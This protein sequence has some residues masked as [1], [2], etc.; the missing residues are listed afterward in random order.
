MRYTAVNLQTGAIDL[1]SGAVGV[2]CDGDGMIST[3]WPSPEYSL[4]KGRPVVFRVG[5][6]YVSTASVDARTGKVIMRSY[7]ATD[8]ERIELST[9]SQ[10]PD[11]SFTDVLLDQEAKVLSW[12]GQGQMPLDGP[13]LGTVLEKL[14][15]K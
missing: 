5:S 11:F 4:A 9:G 8:Y 13:E 15:R 14:L 12:G 10:I 3:V 2:D 1:I 6:S 7:R